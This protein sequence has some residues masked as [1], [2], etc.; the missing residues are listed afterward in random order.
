MEPEVRRLGFSAA[1][2]YAIVDA[3]PRPHPLAC[4]AEAIVSGDDDL[5]VLGTWRG[6]EI[7]SPRQLLTRGSDTG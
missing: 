7:L 2:R 6:I 5:L 1:P 3:R 4:E